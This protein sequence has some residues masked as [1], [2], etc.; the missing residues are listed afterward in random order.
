M[1]KYPLF[2]MFILSAGQHSGIATKASGD[3][4][5][6]DLT[7]SLRTSSMN[8]SMGL[9]DHAFI[10]FASIFAD[11]DMCQNLE[12]IWQHAEDYLIQEWGKLWRKDDLFKRKGGLCIDYK[13][14]DT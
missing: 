1:D 10:T 8:H 12:A 2:N 13:I 7:T 6:I 5:L 11:L 3:C 4:L 14:R 9:P